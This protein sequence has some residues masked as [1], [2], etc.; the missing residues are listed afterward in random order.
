MS[1]ICRGYVGARPSRYLPE[2]GPRPA[3]LAYQPKWTSP[4]ALPEKLQ[5]PEHARNDHG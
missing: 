2:A 5:D 3:A 4:T 1:G